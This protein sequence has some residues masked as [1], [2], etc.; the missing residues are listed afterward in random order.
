MTPPKATR[1]RPPERHKVVEGGQERDEGEEGEGEGEGEGGAGAGAVV[2]I[3]EAIA[4]V[5]KVGSTVTGG[6]GRGGGEG[7]V[8]WKRCGGVEM[9]CDTR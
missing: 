7:W 4:R 1:V 2:D 6:G 5:E 9:R 3:R 8:C